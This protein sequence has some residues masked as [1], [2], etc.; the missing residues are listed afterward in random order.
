MLFLYN[1]YFLTENDGKIERT[2]KRNKNTRHLSRNF[3]E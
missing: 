3:I 2:T 1:Y